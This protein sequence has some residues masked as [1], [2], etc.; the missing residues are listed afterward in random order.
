M[1]KTHFFK[2]QR[3]LS[4][5]ILGNLALAITKGIAGVLGNSFALIAD[6]I[7][8]LSDVFSSVLLLIGLK[9]ATKPPDNDHPYGHGRAESLMTF[10]VV[11]FLIASAG[12]IAF[13]SIHNI[14]TPH[15]LP[16]PFTL[17]VLG[18]IILSK[19]FFY[20]FVSRTGKETK[21][22]SLIADAW[23]HRADAITSLAAFIGIG[24]ALYM[25]KGYESADDWAALV[26]CIIILFNAFMIFRPALSEVMDE[27]RHDTFAQKIKHL[28][29]QVEGVIVTEKCFVRKQGM[30]YV[31]DLHI[32]VNGDISVKKGHDIAHVVK[33]K[34]KSTFPEIV[35]TMIHVEPSYESYTPPLLSS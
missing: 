15:A 10:V 35:E 12:I 16:K 29:K 30:Q 9:Y 34:L 24:I 6:A 5:G 28:S 7:E 26:A 19:E 14:M 20:R 22:T 27:Q 21:S 32:I 3:A 17:I 18:I 8:S 4:L 23:H 31:V 13:Q 1:I 25:G 33:R 2:A 11:A